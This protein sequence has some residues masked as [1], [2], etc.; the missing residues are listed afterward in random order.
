MRKLKLDPEDLR[1]ETFAAGEPAAKIGTVRGNY[2]IPGT[3][4]SHIDCGGGGG[5]DDGDDPS[6]YQSCV[7]PTYR[8]T[9]AATCGLDYCTDLTCLTHDYCCP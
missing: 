3:D 7:C 6:A 5:G 8:K 2:V 1:V 9:C 4:E